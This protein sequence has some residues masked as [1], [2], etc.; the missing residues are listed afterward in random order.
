M[1]SLANHGGLDLQAEAQLEAA[2]L[3]FLA[4]AGLAQASRP[5]DTE[6][7]VGAA[8][9]Q[10]SLAQLL[11]VAQVGERAGAAASVVPCSLDPPGCA[12]YCQVLLLSPDELTDLKAEYSRMEPPHARPVELGEGQVRCVCWAPTPAVC[13]GGGG[14]A[15]G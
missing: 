8:A 13:G 10:H 3:S 5:Q 11:T 1:V 12:C 2:K 9:A 7:V 4:E 15:P 14:G 6:F